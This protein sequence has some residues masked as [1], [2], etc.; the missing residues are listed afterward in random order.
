MEQ[1]IV[2]DPQL[3]ADTDPGAAATPDGG[4]SATDPGPAGGQPGS[5]PDPRDEQIRQQQKAIRDLNQAVIDSRRGNRGQQP[6]GTIDDGSSFDTPEGKY[7]VAL[8]IA[9]SRI[10]GS[11]EKIIPLYPEV[12]AED[13]ARIRANPMA[14]VSRDTMLSG[15]WKTAQLEIEQAL[16]DRADQIAAQ[17]AAAKPVAPTPAAPSNNP[18][19]DSA[20]D[21]VSPGTDGEQDLWSMP[22]A[23]L[24]KLA[25]KEKAKLSKTSK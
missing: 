1:P 12:P 6:N 13:I 7:A 19:P 24:E 15:D 4:A 16:L 25:M 21:A 17:K 14:F 18:A 11:I 20:A 23:D 9:E 10:R 3:T 22:M 8:E 5:Q 2:T